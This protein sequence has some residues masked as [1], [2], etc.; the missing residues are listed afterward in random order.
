MTVKATVEQRAYV[1]GVMDF[2][3]EIDLLDTS[4]LDEQ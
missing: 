4:W 3:S 1:A 2:Q